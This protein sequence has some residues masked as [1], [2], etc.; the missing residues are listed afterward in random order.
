[1]ILRCDFLKSKKRDKNCFIKMGVYMKS[2]L[3]I[4]GDQPNTFQKYQL[5]DIRRSSN[6]RSHGT[7]GAILSLKGLSCLEGA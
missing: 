3:N 2:V 4:I 1:M 6:H 5:F 7:N